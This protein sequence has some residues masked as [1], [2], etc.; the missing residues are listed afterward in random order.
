MFFLR[1]FCRY[2]G[3]GRSAEV[4]T[5]TTTLKQIPKKTKKVPTAMR[6]IQVVRKKRMTQ[7]ERAVQKKA[8]IAVRIAK[9]VLDGLK[10]RISL[11]FE[12]FYTCLYT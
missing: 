11:G 1:V 6:A 9:S 10:C 4:G 2:S 8:R 5:L 12:L 7:V 3:Q